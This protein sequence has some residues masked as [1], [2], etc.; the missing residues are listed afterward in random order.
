MYKALAMEVPA[1]KTLV[2]TELSGLN[3][4]LSIEVKF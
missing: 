3:V 4:S 2:M 1:K